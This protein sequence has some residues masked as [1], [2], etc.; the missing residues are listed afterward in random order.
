MKLVELRV[1]WSS[2]CLADRECNTV[3]PLA[4]KAYLVGA[5]KFTGFVV[6]GGS[7]ASR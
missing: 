5:V 6:L 2:A 7:L 1:R 3:S 4:G